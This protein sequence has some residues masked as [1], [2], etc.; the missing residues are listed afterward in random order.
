MIRGGRR[1]V[2]LIAVGIIAAVLAGC[3]GKG[4]GGNKAGRDID[5]GPLPTSSPVTPSPTGP[6]L[7]LT[8]D[9]GS[10]ATA[11]RPAVAVPI[12]ISGSTAPVGLGTADLVYQEFA[13]GGLQRLIAV[14]QSRDAARVGPIGE[15]RPADIKTLAVLKPVYGHGAGVDS[16]VRQIATAELPAV[17]SA[18]H[19]EAFSGGYTSTQALARLG[20]SVT[21]PPAVFTFAETGDDLATAGN[22]LA[23]LLAITAPGRPTQT[24]RYDQGTRAW[25]T[26]FNGVALAVSTVVVLTMP[27][28]VLSLRRPARSLPDAE[29]NGAGP[30]LAVSGGQ[31]AR[32]SWSKPGTK[33]LCNVI[34]TGGYPMRF[35]PGA[36]WIVYAP[37]HTTVTVR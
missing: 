25:Q 29:I 14:Y 17:S 20:R 11:V 16:I 2:P 23:S 37:P 36:S 22:G 3:G 24:W 6:V 19:P 13:E 4:G 7:P 34:D 35:A 31:S 33:L 8:G 1:V 28:K 5:L 26:T 9:V 18:E 15:P 32:G 30:A 12:A 10:E 27:Y 21:A